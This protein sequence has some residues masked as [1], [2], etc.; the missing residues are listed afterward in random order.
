MVEAGG[1]DNP[2]FTRGE[3][4]STPKNGQ[5]RSNG[6]QN[7]KLRATTQIVVVANGHNKD[8]TKIDVPEET[9]K[10]GAQQH[11]KKNGINGGGN[12]NSL[13]NN[14]CTSV[15]TNGGGEF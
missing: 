10:S 7:D 13:F 3:D 4:G 1:K 15:Q 6:E 9:L 5:A 14:S 12:D 2:A 8:D 11:A